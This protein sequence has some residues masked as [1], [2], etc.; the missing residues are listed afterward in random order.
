MNIVVTWTKNN[1]AKINQTSS[2]ILIIGPAEATATVP[3]SHQL[4][5][6]IKEDP[7]MEDVLQGKLSIL[8]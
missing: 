6:A 4:N 7:Q 5:V 1:N 2:A 3:V 8:N